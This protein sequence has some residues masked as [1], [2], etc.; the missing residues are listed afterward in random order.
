MGDN[1][2]ITDCSTE[3]ANYGGGVYV[4]SDTCTFEMSGSAKV[5]VS[6]GA[7]KNKE[8]ANEIFLKYG[9][10]KV[11]GTLTAGNGQAG[12]I[13]VISSKYQT[14]TVVLTGDNLP[15]NSGKFTVTKQ[16]GLNQAWKVSPS[17]KLQK[18]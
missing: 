4:D 2:E 10:I 9:V 5:T 13:S 17:G 11:T 14:S 3:N 7:D 15:T 18:N 16:K 6:T 1:A 8:G 12:R